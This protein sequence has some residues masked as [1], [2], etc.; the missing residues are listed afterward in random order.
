MQM[1]HQAF[2]I[3]QDLEAGDPQAAGAYN[4]HRRVDALGM[5]DDVPRSQHDLAKARALDGRQFRFQRPG[6]GDGVHAEIGNVR[7]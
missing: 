6:Q 1:P 2:E 5:P 4:R 7:I 3:A